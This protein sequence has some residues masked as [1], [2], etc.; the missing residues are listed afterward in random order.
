MV[1][2]A[3]L[4]GSIAMPVPMSYRAIAADLAARITSGEYPPGSKLPSYAELALLYSVS[5]STAQ[6]AIALLQDRGVVVGAT[7][8]GLY[9]AE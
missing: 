7:G 9:V 4:P 6:R 3:G 8:R 1:L 5:V 2:L